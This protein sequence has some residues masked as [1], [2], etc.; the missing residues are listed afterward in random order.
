[1]R[2]LCVAVFVTIMFGTAQGA[3]VD[4]T[5]ASAMPDPPSRDIPQTIWF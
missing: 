2:A 1:M 4:L 5:A 3:A